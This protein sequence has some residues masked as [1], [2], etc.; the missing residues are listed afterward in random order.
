M[1]HQDDNGFLLYESRAI[2][3]YIAEKYAN[4][5]APLIPGTLKGRALF[6][7]AASIELTNFDLYAGQ[8]YWAT[9]GIK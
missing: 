2:G 3:R 7:Q 1:N 9:D 8:A 4:Q 6:E 5:G